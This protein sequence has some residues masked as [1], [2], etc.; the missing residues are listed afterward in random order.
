MPARCGPLAG[1]ARPAVYCPPAPGHCAR[2]RPLPPSRWP[3][4]WCRSRPVPSANCPA[5]GLPAAMARRAASPE[6]SKV[7]RPWPAHRRCFSADQ[8]ARRRHNPHR[9]PDNP[10]AISAIVPAHPPMRPAS[11][12]L[13]D[14]PCRAISAPQSAA[15]GTAPAGGNHKQG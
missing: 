14:R 15:G 9:F 6:H 12:M 5:P 1:S 7:C 13:S 8:R 4:M 2:Q 11:A 3:A 10:T